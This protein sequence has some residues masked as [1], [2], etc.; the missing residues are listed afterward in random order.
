MAANRAACGGRAGLSRATRTF[1][2][3]SVWR[4]T[5]L[6]AVTL[7]LTGVVIAL[8]PLSAGV[9]VLG[10]TAYLWLAW[11]SLEEPLV[12]ITVFLAGLIVLPPVYLPSLGAIPIYPTALL[13][14]IGAAIVV[15]RWPDFR[16]GPDRIFV[17]FG[18][19][20]LFTG[21]SL[22]FVWIFSGSEDGFGSLLRWLMLAQ[23]AL[24]Y[25][26]VRG[27]MRT[28][29]TRLERRL[30]PVLF[31][32][33]AVTAIY[34]VIDFIWPVP[35]PHP[36]ADQF[37]W[38]GSGMIRRAQGVFFESS[39][40]ANMCG[41]F[42]VAAAAAFLAGRERAIR[43]SKAWLLFFAAVLAP[44]V[45][46]SF[47]RSAWG[48]ILTAVVVF[49][50]FFGRVRTGRVALLLFIL[51]LPLLFLPLYSPELWN[52]FLVTRV[53]D[54][55]RIFSDPNFVSSGRIDVWRRIA[56]ILQEHPIDFIFG[57]GYK[58]LPR[59]RLFHQ[60]I[61]ADNGFLSLLL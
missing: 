9:A 11:A 1:A 47:S 44:A 30:I 58:S 16:L 25:P 57:I 15:F 46:V 4:W 52:Y 20:L 7:L 40:F 29:E 14:P 45:L 34:G 49:G 23:A 55:S 31:A 37:I 42:L 60:P 48:C 59:T 26:I 17:A 10:A 8:A 28:E 61:V 36:A 12:Y 2:G 22:P 50:V 21:A 51:C 43:I 32:A 18:C 3:L 6:A 35:I 19:F 27:G 53:G 56:G 54:F 24:I 5:G 41:F 38:L 13:L 39:S 33:A